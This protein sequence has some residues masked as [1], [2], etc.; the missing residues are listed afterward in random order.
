MPWQ[1]S[2][3]AT[4]VQ[5]I[6][7]PCQATGDS[8]SSLPYKTKQSNDTVLL[9]QSSTSGILN[10]IYTYSKVRPMEDQQLGFSMR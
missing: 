5:A 10:L 4:A 1:I 2:K 3:Y 7:L 6:N 9:S 8:F